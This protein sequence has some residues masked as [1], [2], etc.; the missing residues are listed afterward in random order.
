MAERINTT[1]VKV[2]L[3]A[4]LSL[5]LGVSQGLTQD[6]SSVLKEAETK[7]AKLEKEVQDMTIV[8]EMKMVT[9]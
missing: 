7:Y 8:E 9:A 6:W 2:L 3:V 1:G 4:L 5:V